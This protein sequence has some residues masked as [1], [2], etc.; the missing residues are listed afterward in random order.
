MPR[1]NFPTDKEFFSL[2]DS[3]KFKEEDPSKHYS[4]KE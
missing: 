1:K 3:I 4:F 2:V